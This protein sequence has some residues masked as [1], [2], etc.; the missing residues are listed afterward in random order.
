MNLKSKPL[1]VLS[2]AVALVLATPAVFANE[3]LNYERMNVQNLRQGERYD[4]LIVK[5]KDGTVPRSSESARLSAL[6][7]AA[8]RALPDSQVGTSL[9]IVQSRRLAI[10]ADVISL[11]RKIDSVEAASLMQQVA[12]DPNVEYVETPIRMEHTATP[13]DPLYQSRQWAL[14]PPAEVAGGINLPPALDHSTGEGVV[15]AVLDTGV[16]AHPDL[17]ANVLYDEGYDFLTDKLYSGRATDGRIPGGYDPGD[18]ETADMCGRTNDSSWHG[19]HVAG[20]IAAV[21]NN[22]IGMAGAAPDAVILPVRVLGHCGGPST[23]I[24]DA[25]VWAAGGKTVPGVPAHTQNVEVINMSLGSRGSVICPNIY[26]DALAYAKSRGVTV[27]VAAGNSNGDVAK[28]GG[29]GHTMGNCSDDI[30]VVGGVQSNAARYSSSNYGHRVDIAAPA[31]GVAS[32]LN[33]GTTVPLE[34][35]YVN[36]TGTSM[37][38]PHVAGVVALMQAAAPTHLT[39]AQIKQMLMASARPFP[40][41]QTQINGRGILEANAAVQLAMAGPCSATDNACT[42]TAIRLNNKQPY[43]LRA[44]TAGSEFLYRIDV[45][46]GARNL[47]ILTTG[48]VGDVNVLVSRGEAPT[49]AAAQLSSTRSGNSEVIRVATPQAGTYFIR[50]IGNRAYSGVRLE[51]RYD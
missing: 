30:V 11:S 6:D 39:P 23:D 36:Y 27:V 20:T 41:T 3:A 26:K 28:A 8:K 38:S 49:L 14:K 16:T 21:T 42:A 47:N 4:Q 46:E 12:N 1:S 5:Y 34:P 31:V 33:T 32:T 15:V 24:A 48:G 43:E 22:G 40:V 17:A 7:A 45:P 51:V 25:I 10:G 44:G 29:V 9:R 19:T 18:W 2:L 35:N 13:T 37:A 50:L